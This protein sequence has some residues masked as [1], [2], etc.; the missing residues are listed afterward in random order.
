MTY[1]FDPEK[2]FDLKEAGLRR[3]LAS[4]ELDERGFKE[5][6]DELVDEYEEL[7]KRVDIRCDY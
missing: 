7:L 6:L 3:R 2:W 5:A 1:N 4:G